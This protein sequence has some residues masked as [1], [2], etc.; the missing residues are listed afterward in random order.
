VCLKRTEIEKGLKLREQIQGRRAVAATMASSKHRKI[1]P[2]YGDEY[3]IVRIA[4]LT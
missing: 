1:G 2:T 4:G 3:S